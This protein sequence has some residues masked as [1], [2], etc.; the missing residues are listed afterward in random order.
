MSILPDP[1]T[2]VAQP[3]HA[4]W[5]DD[6]DDAGEWDQW[7]RTAARVDVI[8]A[9]GPGGLME[10]TVERGTHC[11]TPDAGWVEHRPGIHLHIPGGERALLA[12]EARRVARALLA[13]ADI[14]D[15]VT[16]GW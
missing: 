1:A 3:L 15:G 4:P 7:C 13:A 14:R 16:A 11:P 5:C 6:H 10:V 12:H 2:A 9:H 8:G